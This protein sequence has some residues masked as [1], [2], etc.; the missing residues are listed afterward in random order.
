MK[1]IKIQAPTDITIGTS[2]KPKQLPA[3]G[4]YLG[5]AGCTNTADIQVGDGWVCTNCATKM[6]EGE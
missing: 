4:C 2:G 3:T 5:W 1:K 6:R